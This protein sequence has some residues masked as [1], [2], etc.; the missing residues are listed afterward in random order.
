MRVGD[1]LASCRSGYH[2]GYGLRTTDYGLFFLLL[3]GAGRALLN[4]KNVNAAREATQVHTI[5]IERIKAQSPHS[6]R[7][8]LN[9]YALPNVAFVSRA[10]HSAVRV[11]G[12]H[13]F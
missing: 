1:V 4:G 5:S 3:P 12:R 13:H 8:Q 10:I 9:V 11:F 6:I 7:W 2:T